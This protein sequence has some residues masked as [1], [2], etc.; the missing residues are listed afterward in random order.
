MTKYEKQLKQL[1]ELTPENVNFINTPIDGIDE[2]DLRF[3][4]AKGLVKMHRL[5]GNT[6]AVSVTAKG[7][8]Y[9]S[10]KRSHSRTAVVS[11]AL[12]VLSTLTAQALWLFLQGLLQQVL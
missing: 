7:L 12:G 9:F 10:D 4:S 3:L 1:I 6:M 8:T 5:G 2:K 11:F